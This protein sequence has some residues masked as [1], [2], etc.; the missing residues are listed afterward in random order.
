MAR[1][2]YQRIFSVYYPDSSGSQWLF[3]PHVAEN[4]FLGLIREAQVPVIFGERLD[5][6]NGV[7]DREPG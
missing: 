2:F 7:V 1:E 3:E 5:L 6:D 4:V